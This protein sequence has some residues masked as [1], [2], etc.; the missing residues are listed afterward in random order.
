[1]ARTHYSMVR[2]KIGIIYVELSHIHLIQTLKILN[3]KLMI[4]DIT[5][6]NYQ[7]HNYVSILK[8]G[9]RYSNRI[10]MGI[11]TWI[12]IHLL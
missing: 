3:Q 2:N 7:L 10:R 4:D 8:I 1:M 11:L 6:R 12:H 5:L 9:T